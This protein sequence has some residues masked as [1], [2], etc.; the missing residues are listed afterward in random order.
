M[1]E[2]REPKEIEMSDE[3]P[4]RQMPANQAPTDDAA[5]GAGRL[6]SLLDL[7][8]VT[9]AL[10]ALVIIVA[11]VVITFNDDSQGAAT[12]LGVVIPALTAAIGL[13]AGVQAGERSGK[14]AGDAKAADAA[15]LE[16]ARIQEM[17]QPLTESLRAATGEVT[18][19][20]E[21][22]ST[23][24]PGETERV[25]ALPADGTA[26]ASEVRWEGEVV[27][28]MKAN[29]AQ[30]EGLVQGLSTEQSIAS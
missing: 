18:D 11:I 2:H 24:A 15:K 22:A 26:A 6:T 16:R 14:A 28:G 21:A 5:P 25:I 23:S 4:T 10:V 20:L 1:T 8:R 13:T 9:L 3:P 7:Q 12:V 27:D 17:M 29:V 30:L 19:K